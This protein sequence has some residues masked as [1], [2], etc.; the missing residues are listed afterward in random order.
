MCIQA[1]D[2]IEELTSTVTTIKAAISRG[3]PI[4][5][6]TEKIQQRR[7]EII[8]NISNRK[9]YQITRMIK[10]PT[11]MLYQTRLR[12]EFRIFRKLNQLQK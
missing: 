6:G 9:P 11:M 1:K 3:I 2:R 12:K 7:K 5:L 8:E 10:T 4:I